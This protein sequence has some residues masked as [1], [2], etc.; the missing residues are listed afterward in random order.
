MNDLTANIVRAELPLDRASYAT[1]DFD[2]VKQPTN[3]KIRFDIKRLY[4]LA[5]ADNLD[6]ILRR[7]L[8]STRRLVGMTNL[9]ERE[10][11][12]LLRRHRPGS[13]RLRQ[14]VLIR[15]QR[16]MSPTVS[17]ALDDDLEPADWYELLN[18]FVFF[19][20]TN[21]DSLFFA[22]Q[23]AVPAMKKQ[24]V[25]HIVQITTSLVEHALTTVPAVLA[26]LSKDRV[27][28]RLVALRWS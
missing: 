8:M 17:R 3:K 27:L 1:A 23:A 21:L 7:G 9:P 19:W 14:G 13:V 12:N 26:S 11:K 28:P 25:G 4:R 15:D 5:E 6:S 16:P 20:S 18:G 22:T 2:P 10:R 24:G